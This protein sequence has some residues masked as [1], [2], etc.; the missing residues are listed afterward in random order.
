[1]LPVVLY[2]SATPSSLYNTGLLCGVPT[3]AIF[4]PFKLSNPSVFP[5]VYP[6]PNQYPDTTPFPSS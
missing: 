6:A 4:L 5:N 1:M 2:P 3:M